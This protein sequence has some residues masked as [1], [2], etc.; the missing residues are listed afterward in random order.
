MLKISAF[1]LEK[2]KSFTP[3][4]YNLGRGLYIGQESFNRQHFAVPIFQEGFDDWFYGFK[5]CTY[6]DNLVLKRQKI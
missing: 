5:I 3:K 1:Y 6:E 2:Q 4:K